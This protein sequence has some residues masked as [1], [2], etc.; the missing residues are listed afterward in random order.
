MGKSFKKL[1]LVLHSDQCLVGITQKLM[2]VQSLLS[3]LLPYL[4]LIHSL[5]KYEL[6]IYHV[7]TDSATL[8]HS[9]WGSEMHAGL[10]ELTPSNGSAGAHWP[11]VQDQT[12]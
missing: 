11:V 8:L 1:K 5:H 6:C 9:V 3:L 4:H 7:L 10:K 2:K 12:W